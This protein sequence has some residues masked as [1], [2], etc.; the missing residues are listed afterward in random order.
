MH[1]GVAL[2]QM[3]RVRE[4]CIRED[5]GL[6]NKEDDQDPIPDI[7]FIDERISEAESQIRAAVQSGNRFERNRAKERREDLIRLKRVEQLYASP[8]L[9]LM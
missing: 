8:N 9:S 3:W 4:E 6:T 2:W 7:G 5:A 1:I